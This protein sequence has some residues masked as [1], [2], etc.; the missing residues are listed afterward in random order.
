MGHWERTEINIGTIIAGSPKKVVFQALETVPK[1][2]S[3]IPYCGCTATKYDENT[4]ELWITYSNS[5][6]PHQVR[7]AQVVQKKIDI[8]YED[9]SKEVLTIYATRLR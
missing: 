4:R 9:D 3:I 1:I 8:I 5:P 6:I 2:K 7:G